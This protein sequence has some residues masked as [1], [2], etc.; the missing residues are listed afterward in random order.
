MYRM[1]PV[2]IYTDGVYDLFHRG[3][4][5]SLKQ[6]KSLFEDTYLI[7]GVLSDEVATHY[8]REPIYKEADRYAL[9]ENCKGVDQVI[10][11]AP[12]VITE[13]FMILHNIDYVIHGFSNPEDKHKQDD[14]FKIPKQLNKFKEIQYYSPISTTQIIDRVIKLGKDA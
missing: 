11:N 5:E 10:Q 2:R 6:C 1:N 12:L 14:F 3:H 8:K 4:V 13:E 7:V 9:L